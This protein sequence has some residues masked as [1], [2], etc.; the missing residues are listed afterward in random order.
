MLKQKTIAASVV[1]VGVCLGAGGWQPA[2]ATTTTYDTTYAW[3]GSGLSAFGNPNTATM[4]QTF[5]A[6]SADI[7]QGFTFY[8]SGAADLQFQAQVYAWSGSLTGGNG[9]Q[10][11]VGSPLYTSTPIPFG[12]TAGAFV[13][14]NITTGGTTL[15]AGADYVALLTISGPNSSNYGSSTG[16]DVFGYLPFSHVPGNGGGGLNY[17]NNASDYPD[18]NAG[19]W[20]DFLDYGDAAWTAIFTSPT[21]PVPEPATLTIVG[22]GLA[23][24]GMVR[25]RR[26][27]A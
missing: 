22:A 7:L 20:D 14:V 4:G 16:T 10:G 19:F 26:K 6:P 1:A 12:S 9:R 17:Y 5:V 11:A 25:R 3:G 18:I 23:G 8:L 24:L 2:Q 13:P 21:V 27:A 15:T